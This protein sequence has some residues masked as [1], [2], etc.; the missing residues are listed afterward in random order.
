SPTTKDM[1]PIETILVETV[2]PEGPFGA[3]ECG[4]GPL[5]PVIP[6]VANAVED[7]IGA[8]FH[9]IPIT[10]EKVLSAMDK[11][12]RGEEPLIG[13]TSLPDYHLGEVLR[14]DPPDGKKVELFP[15][16]EET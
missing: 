3:K 4:Q 9:E 10:P 14:V 12:A 1:P 6:A 5:L 15:M 11:A 2:D 16:H 13:P 7:A 8:R